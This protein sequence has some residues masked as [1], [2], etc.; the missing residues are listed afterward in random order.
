M[1]ARAGTSMNQ[2]RG[3]KGNC[4]EQSNITIIKMLA[5]HIVARNIIFDILV[6][7]KEHFPFGRSS[8]ASGTSHIFMNI[9]ILVWSCGSTKM[10]H[11][12]GLTYRDSFRAHFHAFGI[13]D[14][15]DA[16]H[17]LCVTL[18]HCLLLLFLVHICAFHDGL[19]TGLLQQ[20][21]AR[22]AKENAMVFCALEILA[23]FNCAIVT[24]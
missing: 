21:N 6:V 18:G 20:G 11:P 7:G 1:C 22:W 19:A 23:A 24:T 2:Y 16:T 3:G 10:S 17:A 9:P 8:A 15:V 12:G 14:L 5:H 13:V 4:Y